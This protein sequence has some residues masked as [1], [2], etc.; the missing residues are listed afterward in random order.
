MF[1]DWCRRICRFFRFHWIGWQ[2][3]R[4]IL[5]KRA[6]LGE[7]FEALRYTRPSGTL[8]MLGFLSW[9]QFRNGVLIKDAGLQSVRKVTTA[10]AN[11]LVDSFQDTENNLL[12]AFTYHGQGDDNTAESNADTALG[13]SR[14]TRVSGTQTENGA[15]RY[16][17][18]ANITATG[19]YTAEE[20]GFFNASTGGTMLDRNLPANAPVLQTDDV[21]EWSYE[22]LVNAES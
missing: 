8:E 15:N 1:Q 14:E 16:K 2:V 9:R 11:F 17:S 13:N 3:R 10:F 6:E 18:V 7:I 21:V 22:L 20:H 12:D 19:N 5:P 4:G